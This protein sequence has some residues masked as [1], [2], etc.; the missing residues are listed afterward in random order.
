M[1]DYKVRRL[2]RRLGHLIEVQV[3]DSFSFK[4]SDI[5]NGFLCSNRNEAETIQ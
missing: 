4:R 5:E 3:S 2:A 1:A